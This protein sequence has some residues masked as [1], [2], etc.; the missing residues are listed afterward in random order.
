MGEHTEKQFAYLRQRQ[1]RDTH[2]ERKGAGVPLNEEGLSKE[3]GQFFWAFICFWPNIC[4]LSHAWPALGYSPTRRCSSLP[5][6]IPA[7]RRMGGPCHHQLLSGTPSFLTLEETSCAC[8]KCLPCP[9]EGK[10]VTS[11]SFAQTEF[12][13]LCLTCSLTCSPPIS[14]L[15]KCKQ[16]ESFKCATEAYLSPAS[17]G[18]PALLESREC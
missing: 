2:V 17:G 8:R 14:C 4:L 7:Q 3:A 16:E 5:K 10:Y 18:V 9:K 15:R 1:G 11:W 13:P 6:S 12:G